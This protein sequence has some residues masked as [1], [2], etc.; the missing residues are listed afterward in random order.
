MKLTKALLLLVFCTPA[1]YAMPEIGK[2]APDFVGV[3]SNG[4]TVQLTELRGKPV[5]L[6][7]TNHLCPYVRK[8]YESGNMQRIQRQLTEDGAKW[9][10]IISSAPGKQGHVTS[11]EANNLTA[12][13]GVYADRVVLDPEGTIGRAYNAKT[14]PQMFLIDEEGIVRY[15]GAIDDKP[16]SRPSTLDTATNY[17]LAAWDAFRDGETIKVANTKPYGC[18]VKYSSIEGYK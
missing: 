9:I 8:H 18:T 16:S 7:W 10:S 4:Q 14:T 1:A 11:E 15:M 13:R 3:D 5:I 17:L 12:S 6:E 2:E